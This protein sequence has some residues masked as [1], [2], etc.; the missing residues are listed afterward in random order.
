MTI[1]D[2]I[3]VLC[4]KIKQNEAQYDLDR[5]AAKIS[6]FSSNNL[7]K[8][9]Y[10]T[11]EDLDYK[12]SVIEQARLEYS[13]LGTV[14]NKGLKEEDEKGGLLKRRRNIEDKIEKQLKTTKSKNDIKSEIDIFNEELSSEAVALLKEIKHIG[15][16]VD[17]S[18]LFFMGGNK[19]T[20]VLRILRCLKS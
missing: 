12:P 17:Y 18:K 9:Q 8:Y 5:E 10:L 13:P 1:A 6:A 14:F 7:D 11:G 19:T 4:R 20:T 16:N 15:D 3:K 2:Q